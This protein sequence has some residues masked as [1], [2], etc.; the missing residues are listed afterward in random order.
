MAAARK[1]ADKAKADAVDENVVVL[2]NEH[3]STVTVDASNKDQIDV[4]TAYGFK[5]STK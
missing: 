1:S 4:L 5:K 2:V 3:G